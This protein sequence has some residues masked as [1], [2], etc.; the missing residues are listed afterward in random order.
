MPSA[1]KMR[2]N[3]QQGGPS[4]LLSL[5]V[6]LTPTTLT[7]KYLATYLCYRNL[8]QR[9]GTPRLFRKQC[10]SADLQP[11]TEPQEQRGLPLYT[12]ASRLQKQKARFHPY[13]VACNS[14]GYFTPSA[15]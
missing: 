13:M 2:H 12:L 7:E 14:I 8:E 15:M 6:N 5:K 11:K 3:P 4:A 10:G 1:D 9:H